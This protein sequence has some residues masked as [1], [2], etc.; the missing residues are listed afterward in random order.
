MKKLIGTLAI[1]SLLSFALMGCTPQ[2]E[3]DT[4]PPEPAKG[5]DQTE[6]TT[7]NPPSTDSK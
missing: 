1:A 3:G 4:A 5:A 6:T 2:A 7:A